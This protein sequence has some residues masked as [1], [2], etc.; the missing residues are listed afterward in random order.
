MPSTKKLVIIYEQNT[1][2]ALF[3]HIVIWVTFQRNLNMTASKVMYFYYSIQQTFCY[4]RVFCCCISK[5]L[6]LFDSMF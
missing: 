3:E 6:I 2:P 1:K 5:S 4:N